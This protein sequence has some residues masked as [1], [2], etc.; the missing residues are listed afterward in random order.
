MVIAA[1]V[2]LAGES[3]PALRGTCAGSKRPAGNDASA[4]KSQAAVRFGPLRILA[5]ASRPF[6]VKKERKSSREIGKG[7]VSTCADDSTRQVACN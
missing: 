7:Y 1:K 4:Y 5:R 3:R 2:H 6:F